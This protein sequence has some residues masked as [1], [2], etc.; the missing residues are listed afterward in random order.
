[1]VL[2]LPFYCALRFFMPRY[3][4]LPPGLVQATEFGSRV[5]LFGRIISFPIL[6]SDRAQ[7][8]AF[9]RQKTR[10]GIKPDPVMLF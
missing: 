7:H 10:S 9:R 6:N 8:S 5:L 3:A 2:H 4:P 1:M